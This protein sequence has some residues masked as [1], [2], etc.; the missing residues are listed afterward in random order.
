MV[1]THSPY[2]FEIWRRTPPL[3][4]PGQFRIRAAKK[5]LP[6]VLEF[7]T[8]CEGR[9]GDHDSP[10][11]ATNCWRELAYSAVNLPE[12]HFSTSQPCRLLGQVR[13]CSAP[14]WGICGIG[15]E[16]NALITIKRTDLSLLNVASRYVYILVPQKFGTHRSSNQYDCY[17]PVDL[18]QKY[19]PNVTNVIWERSHQ[20]CY[21][22]QLGLSTP[23]TDRSWQSRK[24][25]SCI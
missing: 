21:I 17:S 13:G 24:L 16:P 11:A 12:V 3:F 20:V 7:G 2:Y 22:S 23:F 9:S 18:N 25:A 4:L 15:L 1:S 14:I 6:S 5:W 19:P 10:T 8:C